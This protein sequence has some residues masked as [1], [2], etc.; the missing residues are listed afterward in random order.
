MRP[1]AAAA[2]VVALLLTVSLVALLPGSARAAAPMGASGPRGVGPHATDSILPTNYYG[3]FSPAYQTGL[4]S[5]SVYFQAYDPSDAQATVQIND[6]NATRDG[7]TNPVKSWTVNLNGGGYN[8]SWTWGAYYLIPLNLTYGGTWN[9]TIKG[10][11]AGFSYSNFTVSTY[12]V[13]GFTNARAY[14]PDHTGQVYYFVYSTV[15]SAPFTHL[16]NVELTAQYYTTGGTWVRLNGTPLSLGS[17][18][19][20]SYNFTVPNNANTASGIDFTFFA[21]A[22]GPT[23]NVSESNDEFAGVGY[24]GAPSITLQSCAVGCVTTSFQVGSPVYVIVNESIYAVSGTSPGAGLEVKFSFTSGANPVTNVPGSPP[25]TLTTN[26]NGGAAILF[27]ADSPPFSTTTLSNVSATVS[28]PLNPPMTPVTSTAT[29]YVIKTTAGVPNFAVTLDS[30]QYYAG[31]TA[32]ATWQLGTSNGSVLQG[33]TASQW[34]AATGGTLVEVGAIG[35]SASQGTFSFQVPVGYAGDIEVEVTAYNATMEIVAF[36]SAIVSPP[37]IFLNPSEGSYLPGDTLSVGVSTAGQILNGATLWATVVDSH[38]NLVVNSAVS[39]GQIQVKIP[40]VGTPSYLNVGV[41]AQT[42]A[43]GVVSNASLRVYETGGYDV[44]AGVDTKSSYSDGSFQ[45]GQTVTI[46]YQVIPR[47]TAV[48]PKMFTVTVGLATG[49]F[50]SGAGTEVVQTS[51]ASGSFQYTL[52]SNLPSGTQLFFLEVSFPTCVFMGCGGASEFSLPINSSPSPLAYELGAG[53]GLSVGWL[54]L[55][56]LIVIVAIL[57]LVM[58]RRR[59]GRTMVM[60]PEGGSH[61]SGSGGTAAWQENPPSS[62]GGSP[63]TPPSGSS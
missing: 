23:V 35:S 4:R 21:N 19:S 48:L 20:G 14:L 34:L 50:G 32:T 15:N 49:F 53:S 46:H 42:S 29:F 54:I 16:T 26:A 2:L 25:T 38:G 44:F 59:G 43:N 52:P 7:L 33:W 36:Q 51:S 62:G 27:L 45:P 1:W 22:T 18:W 6:L 60:R 12:Y 30:T 11:V 37:Q 57:G 61:G 58:M 10:T 9:M 5:G 39:N 56:V 17:S 41:I 3:G 31:D 55:L 47:G 13:S 28:D 8:N 24:L 63:P 40:S